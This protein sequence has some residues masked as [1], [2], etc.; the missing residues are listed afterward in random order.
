MNDKKFIE[1]LK[2]KRE[3]YG[4]SQKDLPLPAVS[5]ENIITAL[6]RETSIDR[7]TESGNSETVG[8]I[9][10]IRAYVHTG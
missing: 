6:K 10:S 9:K 7:R 2:F 8:T 4:V 5:V 3:E 1:E